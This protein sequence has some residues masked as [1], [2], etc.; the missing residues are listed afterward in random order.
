VNAANRDLVRWPAWLRSALFRSYLRQFVILWAAGKGANA[1]TALLA[2]L[3][4]FAF[5][6][7]TELGICAIELGILIAFIR[8]PLPIYGTIAILLIAYVARFLPLATR[9]ANA[10]FRQ[11]DPSLEEAGRATGASWWHAVRRILLPL[12][13]PGLLV[14]FLLVFI[15]AFGELS[16]T[17]LLY[18]GGTETIAIAIYRLNDLGQLEV[19][20][21]L[22]IF[23]IA[24]V[25]ALTGLI[26]WLSGSN[27][28][29]AGAPP[30]RG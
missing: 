10:T 3:P 7:L 5:R 25:L 15:P 9:S 20:S 4:P 22:A 18:T 24:V 19:V 30:V 12:A 17:I 21:A 29:F 16:A 28:T 11:I 2:G 23:T 8:V 27:R 14:A 13:R 1:F 6:P 26:S